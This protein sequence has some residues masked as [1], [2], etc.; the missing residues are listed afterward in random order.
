MDWNDTPEQAAFRKEVQDVIDTGLPEAYRKGHGEWVQDR[1][2]DNPEKRDAALAWQ[3]ALANKGWIAPH[4]PKEYGGAGL[5]P[6]EQFIFKQ[7]MAMASAP[8]VGGQGVSQLGPTLIIH[9]TDEQKAEH[10]PRILSG[11]VNW[12]QGYSEPGS[13]SDLA[14]LQTRAV[15]DGDDYVVNGQKIWTS[16][17][18][19]ADWL[20]V[21][22]RT[23][24]DA[25]KHRGISFVMIDMQ[26]A[27]PLAPPADRHER[28]L[29]LQ[30]D[31]LRGRAHPRRAT[32]SARRTAAG[33]SARPCSTSSGRTSPAPSRAASR[34]RSWS[35]SSTA[36]TARSSRGWP[37]PTRCGTGVA[38]RYVETEVQFQFS[39]RIISMQSAG[40]V[41]NYE[42]STSKLF[43]SELN[44]KLARTGTQVFGLY[45]Q[46]WGHDDDD[47]NTW[48]TPFN[49]YAPLGGSF[50][51]NYVRSVPSTIAAGTSEIQRNII[52]TRG[53]GLPRG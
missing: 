2:S 13:G 40:Q 33:T 27:R 44:Q 26:D 30:R 47:R 18:Q 32:A 20:Y 25:P 1:K 50:T 22:V 35:T 17:A 28:S 39:F 51:Q 43:N 4:W 29:P 42:A 31:V 15:R 24:A 21:L 3:N 19:Y 49:A 12:Q 14:S 10:L 46:F 23:D 8:A 34:S 41:P 53:L 38:E 7:E 6:M 48:D 11:E 16:G 36:T 45:A 37:S 52:A 5:T 9:G